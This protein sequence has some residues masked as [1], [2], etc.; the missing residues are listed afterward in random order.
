MMKS[1]MIIALALCTFAAFGE[2]RPNRVNQLLSVLPEGTHF[3]TYE[4]QDCSA[5]VS[6]AEYP[7]RSVF[8]KLTKGDHSIFK[9][10]N[11]DS[12]ARFRD[13]LKEFVQTDYVTVDDT[14]SVNVER[15]IR[16]FINDNNKLYV[17]VAEAIIVNRE[18]KTDVIECVVTINN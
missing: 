4:G 7:V 18:R 16:T 6:V 2:E 14:R 3:G 12:E 15:I 1:L 17:V 9:I 8:V 10:V 11:E 5:N 13:H